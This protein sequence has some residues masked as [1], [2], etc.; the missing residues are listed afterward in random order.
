MS[1]LNPWRKLCPDAWDAQALER[2][3]QLHR[4]PKPGQPGAILALAKGFFREGKKAGILVGEMGTGKV[5]RF[6]A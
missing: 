3:Q 4:Q 1:R 6:G 5:R 2:L